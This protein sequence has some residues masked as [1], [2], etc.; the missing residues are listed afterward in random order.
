MSFSLD[1]AT[2]PDFTK[3]PCLEFLNLKCCKSLVEMHISIGSLERLVSLDLNGC[4]KLDTL[5]DTICRLGALEVLNIGNCSSLKALPTQLGNIQSLKQLN[6]D[7][8]SVLE[9]P[10]SIGHLSKL[11]QLRLSYNKNLETLPE[12]IYKLKSLENLDIGYCSHLLYI[13]ELP[14]NLKWISADGCTSLRRLPNLSNLK[15]LEELRLADCS[16]LTEILGLEKSSIRVLHL[17]GCNSSLLAYIT[18]RL[19]QVWLISIPRDYKVY[20]F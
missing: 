4:V 11:V 10:D 3:L 17:R 18:E 12:T 9:L 20:L 16:S 15:H 19:F 14:F 2:T 5:P 13:A 8:L 6:G 7:G 1:L